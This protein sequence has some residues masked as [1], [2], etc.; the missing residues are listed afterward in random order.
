M[1]NVVNSSFSGNSASNGAF[2]GAIYNDGG[3]ATVTGSTFSAN[4][5]YF[6]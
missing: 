3:T 5:A 6:W 4:S 2:G 1:L